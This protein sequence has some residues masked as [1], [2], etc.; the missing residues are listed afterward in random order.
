MAGAAVVAAAKFHHRSSDYV[1]RWT[2]V[3]SADAVAVVAAAEG[4]WAAEAA[5]VSRVPG[6]KEAAAPD[7]LD[8]G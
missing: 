5:A 8:A 2:V 4:T 3:L 6:W 7:D 1:R